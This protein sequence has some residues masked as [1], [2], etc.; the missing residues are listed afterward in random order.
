MNDGAKQALLR[1]YRASLALRYS[2]YYQ[3]KQPL[4]HS[5]RG[6]IGEEKW[7][8]LYIM[9]S[10]TM[11]NPTK[12]TLQISKTDFYFVTGF[13]HL[14][15]ICMRHEGM[16]LGTRRHEEQVFVKALPKFLISNSDGG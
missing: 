5:I 13:Y 9:R 7:L 8:Y 2:P 4:F 6:C 1:H 16:F 3:T 10:T 14:Y 15:D 12:T 11:P